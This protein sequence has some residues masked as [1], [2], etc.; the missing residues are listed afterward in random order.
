MPAAS[1]AG[2]ASTDGSNVSYAANLGEQNDVTVQL[3]GG[4]YTITDTAGVTAGAGCTAAG[5]NSATCPQSAAPNLDH[6]AVGTRD[7]DDTINLATMTDL[8][9]D[10]TRMDGAE[11]NDTLIGSNTGDK[12][13]AGRGD[14]VI[15]PTDVTTVINNG[16]PFV[17]PEACFSD[18]EATEFTMFHCP[19]L[20]DGD[21]GFNTLRFDSKPNGVVIDAGPRGPNGTSV[22]DPN[23][24]D[25]GVAADVFVKGIRGS[26]R[27][28]HIVGTPGNDQIY[29]SINADTMVGRGGADH[30]CGGYGNDTADYSASGG[31]TVTLDSTLPPDPKWNSTDRQQWTLSRGDCRQTNTQG[32]VEPAAQKDCTANDGVNN[33]GE[34]DC[35]GVDTENVIGSGS[36]DV[37]IGNGPG[38]H[39]AKAAFFE[40]R[41]ANRLEGRGGNDTL[42]GGTGADALIGGDGTDTVT[43]AGQTLAVKVS[44]D[45]AANDGSIADVNPDT[46]LGD[47]VGSDVENLTGGSGDD[48]L[49]GSEV[50]NLLLGGEGNDGLLGEGGDD[51]IDGQG[52]N[53]QAFGG[54]GND[55]SVAGGSG[56]DTINGG[57]GADALDGG[58]GTDTVDYSNSTTSVIVLP[59]GVANDGSGGGAEGDNVSGAFESVSGG[60][61][62]DTLVANAG[63]GVLS[64]GGGNDTLDGGG[65]PDMLIGGGGIDSA[66]YAGRG[67]PVAVDLAAGTGGEA[68]EGD[69][70]TQVEAATG[71]N[72]PDDIRGDDVVNILSGGPGD[73]SLEGRGD[74]DTIFGGPGNDVADGG[75]GPDTV[76][77]DAGE[78]NLRGGTEADGVNG[79]DGDDQ[80]DG[81]PGNDIF[82]GGAGND[83]ALY[84]DRATAV[85]VTLDGADNDGEK[86][87]RDQV[88]TT[89]ESTKTGGGNDFVNLRDG[90]KGNVSCGA[91]T[92][93][94]RVDRTDEVASDCEEAT[95]GAAATCAIG[96]NLPRM[97]RRGVVR[98]RVRCARAGRATVRLRTVGKAR[99]A[100]KVGSKSLRLRAGK[101]T[102]VSVKLTRTAKRLL[103]RHKGSLR[104]HAT[105]SVR[106]ST[107]ARATKRSANLTIMAPRWRR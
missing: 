14:D 21:Q 59:D 63:A 87:E 62:D 30:I 46:G 91:G 104:T 86:D 65:G 41:G 107:A 38:A 36:D 94:V 6:L 96:P 19:D 81:G 28:Q 25:N 101:R 43:Y 72:G 23:R 45:E 77:G 47:S 35:V 100:K 3:S 5:A 33:G 29:G 92:D 26:F 95:V 56:D 48:T 24:P 57:P 82:T 16:D 61:A 18:P 66:S 22:L 79:G 52:G 42:D 76:F 10:G 78:D 106:G 67:G 51:T 58:D 60:S 73:D 44:L 20:I 53:D 13:T 39:V 102:T 49:G 15:D 17:D 55:P 37:L 32:Q 80:M 84:S 70:L 97:N 31:V 105:V 69:V 50:N 71:G 54:I 93:S 34:G 1:F 89:V 68:G 7:L 75:A 74:Q 11:G 9:R 88:R 83:T 40:P 103:K 98:L 64:G 12:I 85:D 8:P 27:T 4:V 90:V 99:R 2:T